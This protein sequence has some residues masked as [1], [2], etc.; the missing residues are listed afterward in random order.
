MPFVTDSWFYNL[1]TA[2]MFFCHSFFKQ[3]RHNYT[4]PAIVNAIQFAETFKDMEPWY[5]REFSV[6]DKYA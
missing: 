2:H 5:Y 4:G 3:P 6:T 1:R